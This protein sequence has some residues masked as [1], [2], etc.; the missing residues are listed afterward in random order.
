LPQSWFGAPGSRCLGRSDH[1][2]PA[3]GSGQLYQFFFDAARGRI[4][5]RQ[6]EAGTNLEICLMGGSV[7]RVVHRAAIGH[8]ADLI[9]IGRGTL[10]KLLGR[11]RSAAYS[12]IREAPCPVI[13]SE[14]TRRLFTIKT[15]HIVSLLQDAVTLQMPVFRLKRGPSRMLHDYQLVPRCS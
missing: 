14:T 13:R 7:D 8:D 1:C 2:R 9:I 6:Q 15:Q 3:E 5:K 11:L 12:I 10:Q 4:A